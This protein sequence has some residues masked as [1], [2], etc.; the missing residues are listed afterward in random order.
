MISPGIPKSWQEIVELILRGV[1]AVSK[2][3]NCYITRLQLARLSSYDYRPAYK[4]AS[5]ELQ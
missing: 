3:H 4:V 2:I 5:S 1:C